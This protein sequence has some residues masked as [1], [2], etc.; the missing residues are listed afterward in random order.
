MVLVTV[1]SNPLV[2][3]VV[4]FAAIA[5]IRAQ[6]RPPFDRLAWLMFGMAWIFGAIRV[7]LLTLTSH[8]VGTSWFELPS[9]HFPHWLGDFDLG[10]TIEWVVIAQAS[11]DMLLPIALITVFGALN[12][13]VDHDAL[14]ALL[15]RALARPALVATLALRFLPALSINVAEARIARQARTGQLS[16]ARRSVIVPALSRT[17]EQSSVVGT[18]MELRGFPTVRA[19][20]S[21][22]WIV[23]IGLLIASGLLIVG[24]ARNIPG[25]SAAGILLAGASIWMAQQRT[26]KDARLHGDAVRWSGLDVL[27]VGTCL[28]H[29]VLAIAVTRNGQARWVAS[30]PLTWPILHLP[31]VALAMTLFLPAFLGT[32]PSAAAWSQE[33]G[34]TSHG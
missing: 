7:V 33:P 5:V 21:G 10:G 12:A 20:T 13:V 18:S 32:Q 27:A 2:S 4:M 19:D 22:M 6:G 15:P 9:V 23:P 34:D 31:T 3:I 1:A 24:M 16:I 11:N 26:R 30:E 14:I 25:W 17:L 29:I 8:G 28:T